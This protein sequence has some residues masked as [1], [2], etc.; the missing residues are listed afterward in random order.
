MVTTLRN[1]CLNSTYSKD[2]IKSKYGFTFKNKKYR[3][4]QAFW[5][6]YPPAKKC[7]IS[8]TTFLKRLKKYGENREDLLFMTVEEYR[9]KRYKP[10]TYRGEKY[11]NLNQFTKK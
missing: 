4:V 9:T 8:R 11:D 5:D 10:F 7:K 2:T 6:T 1:K 3:S